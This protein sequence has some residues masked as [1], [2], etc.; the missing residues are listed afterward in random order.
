MLHLSQ[1]EPEQA[2]SLLDSVAPQH[3]DNNRYRFYLALT[4]QQSGA[5]EE[6]Q[7]LLNALSKNQDDYAHKAQQILQKMH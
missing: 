5:V 3:Q 4:K 7:T 1:G 6:S 2:Q